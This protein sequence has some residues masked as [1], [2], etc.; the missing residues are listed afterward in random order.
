MQSHVFA[1]VLGDNNLCQFPPDN[2]IQDLVSEQSFI[3]VP[4]TSGIVYDYIDMFGDC[5]GCVRAVTLCYRPATDTEELFIE[6][7]RN[8]SGVEKTRMVT[9]H[10]DS[11][12]DTYFLPGINDCCFEHV[13]SPPFSVNHNRHYALNLPTGL[14]SLPLRHPS[15]MISGTQ[16]SPI[17]DHII[18]YVVYQPLFY[19]T[20]DTHL[21]KLNLLSLLNA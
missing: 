1:A 6:I 7:R 9:L 21:S 10:S 14:M 3:A 18:V 2:P 4:M 15:E 12:E 5:S 13:F 11:C 19:F 16:R 8:N 20:I 17:D